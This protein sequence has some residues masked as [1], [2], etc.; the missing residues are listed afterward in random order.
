VLAA[1]PAPV[2]ALAEALLRAGVAIQREVATRFEVEDGQI[3]A[4]A[5]HSGRTFEAEAVIS[6]EDPVTT[7]KERLRLCDAEPEVVD[8]LDSWKIQS[9]TGTAG[10]DVTGFGDHGVVSLTDT[11]ASL[12]KAYDPSKYGDS[13]ATPFGELEPAS[14]R[15]WVQHLVGTGCED[16]I[17]PF[18]KSYGVTALDKLSPDGLEREYGVT[19]GHLYGGDPVLW[20]SLWLR[21]AFNRPLANLY[22]CGPGTGRGD[23]SGL[24]GKRCAASVLANADALKRG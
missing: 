13:S 6:G 3:R 7:Y 17:D 2:D 21:E 18:C 1:S 15:V 22:L 19:G 16:R 11:V 9:T 10:V 12:E 8:L 14:Q 23:Y 5:T 24:N 20:Q 4:V